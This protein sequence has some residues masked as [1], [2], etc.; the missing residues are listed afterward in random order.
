MEAL[1]NGR[2]LDVLPVEWTE[3]SAGPLG[4]A[5]LSG[6]DR[7]GFLE[8]VLRVE[9]DRTVGGMDIRAPA[10]DDVLPEDA[11]LVMRFLSI[12]RSGDE[13]RMCAP[14]ISPAVMRLTGPPTGDPDTVAA[15]AIIAETLARIQRATGTRFSLPG[16][17]TNEDSEMPYFC[18]QLLTV[19][20][21]QWYWPGYA[22]NLPALRLAKLLS[23]STLPRVSMTGESGDNPVISLMGGTVTIPGK[24]RC[25]VTD[26]VVMNPRQ[27]RAEL[28]AASPL[29]VLPVPLGQDDRTRSMFYLVREPE[30]D[31]ADRE[32][33]PP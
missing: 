20:Q 19:G 29:T 28:E 15:G 7:S 2:V 11:A 31:E 3:R 24:I 22:I 6:R 10:S 8:L 25:E 26:M 30:V 4:G 27:L 16:G 5:W 32:P 18:D 17:W 21:V 14:G 23:E 1:R 13:L 33:G 9:P 12:L